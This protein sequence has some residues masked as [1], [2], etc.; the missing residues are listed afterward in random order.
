MPNTVL[1]TDRKYA[2][3]ALLRGEE[4]K[5][6]EALYDSKCYREKENGKED[7]RDGGYTESPKAV[8]P[9]PLIYNVS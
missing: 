7:D 1:H 6:Y 3:R 8:K 4:T 2:L 5:V 9:L